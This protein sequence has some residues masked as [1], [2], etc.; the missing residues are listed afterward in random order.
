MNNWITAR[1]LASM[2]ESPLRCPDC[3]RHLRVGVDGMYCSDGVHCQ[4]YTWVWSE[5]AP[6]RE[7]AA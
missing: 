6:P 3:D 4:F 2:P 5:H 1:D 7:V